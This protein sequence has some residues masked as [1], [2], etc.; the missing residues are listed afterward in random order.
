[1]QLPD[2]PKRFRVAGRYECDDGDVLTDWALTGEGIALKPVFEVAEH[3]NAGTLV[4]VAQK[5]PPVPVQMACLYTHRRRQ[6]PK[7]RLFM[8][9]M[10]EQIGAAVQAGQSS[11]TTLA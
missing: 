2:G 1:L 10:T 5:T 3:L 6:D 11:V 9:F 4:R 8:E 7:T